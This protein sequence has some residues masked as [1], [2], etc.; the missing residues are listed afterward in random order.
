MFNCTNKFTFSVRAPTNWQVEEDKE[1]RL[2]FPPIMFYMKTSVESVHLKLTPHKT[3]C[4]VAGKLIDVS[5][6][7][8]V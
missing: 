4:A 8:L 2:Y 1:E 6:F 5:A 3:R 7:S